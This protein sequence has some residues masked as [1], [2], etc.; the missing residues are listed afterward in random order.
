MVTIRHEFLEQATGYAYPV[1]AH[2]FTGQNLEEARRY[3]HAH[4]RYDRML[5]AVAGLGHSH[6][7][8][9]GEWNGIKYRSIIRVIDRP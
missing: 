3:F 6:N 4:L 5:K 9:T 1:V 8:A 7:G 2:E